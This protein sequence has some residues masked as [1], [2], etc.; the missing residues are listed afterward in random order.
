MPHYLECSK[1]YFKAVY[2]EQAF[3]HQCEHGSPTFRVRLTKHAT[4]E[5]F[6]QAFSD[7]IEANERYLSVCRARGNA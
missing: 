3:D 2:L 1:C 4:S 7:L 5:D 6:M